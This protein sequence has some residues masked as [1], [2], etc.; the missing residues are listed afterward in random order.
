MVNLNP[1]L[2]MRNVSLV[3]GTSVAA[4]SFLASVTDPENDPITKYA[5]WDGG[6][7]GGR[8][9]LNGVVQPAGKW[10]VVAAAD[11]GS[12]SYVAAAGNG[13]ERIFGTVYD[14]SSWS[15]TVSA[16]AT[17]FVPVNPRPVV[18][19]SDVTVS[20][21]QSIA[22]SAFVQSVTDANAD[23]ITKYSFY[24]SGIGGGRFVLNGVV[25]QAGKWIVVDA[26]DLASLTYV[27]FGV[28]G[29]ERVLVRA[30]DGTSWSIARGAWATTVN[31]A[32]VVTAASVSV[33][34]FAAV[35]AASLISSAVD[36]DGDT[37]KAYR[38]LDAGIGG[39][40]FTLNG[41][42]QAA[43]VWIAIGAD[44]LGALSYVGGKLPGAETIKIRAFDGKVW[45][46]PVSTTVT[47][48]PSTSDPWGMLSDAA[49]KADVVRLLVGN[50]LDY[51]GLLQIMQD[52]AVGGI[53]AAEFTSLKTL[54]GL[55][56]VTGGITV[57]SYLDDIANH[58]INGDPANK[59]WTGGGSTHVALGNLASGTT[60]TQMDRLI[61]KWLLGTD[62]PTAMSGATYKVDNDPLY[63]V[64]G[65]PVYSD[66]NQGS[67]GDCYLLASFAEI[68]LRDPGTLESMFTDNG[69]GTY[70]VRFF[71]DGKARYVTIDSQLPYDPL[72][73]DNGSYLEY[74]NGSVK[75]AAL[76][77]KAYV[78]LNSSVATAGHVAGNAYS[79]IEAGWADPLTDITGKSFASYWTT[80][81][82]AESGWENNKTSI[83]QAI[84]A[85][86]EV[87]VG[88]GSA[89][90]GNL[91]GGHM[92][93]VLG[94]NS[95]NDTF[96]LYNPWGTAYNG[97]VA[98]T[99]EA[100]MADLF[101]NKAT[102]V[103]AQG[104]A[105]A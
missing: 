35:S 30:F 78:Q 5:F 45:S 104:Q 65:A 76:A 66:V 23:P 97:G 84:T 11:L 14:G 7:G 58:L 46:T 40:Y 27:G 96:T 63:G 82:A 37:I 61:G 43:G 91:I 88:S 31:H 22:A 74:A 60:E 42:R 98:I 87:L 103:T 1:T 99:F 73:W 55:F 44:K 95:G 17:S 90:T 25:Q 71:V 51:A 79:L 26:A 38:F 6:V 15:P 9:V 13:A 57:S 72:A 68:A 53:T 50:S 16:M 29:S 54:D 49:I 36:P 47:S 24:D 100:S 18:T 64:S 10:I 94:Y 48:T 20:A 81:Y 77:E 28:G 80:D 83:V 3:A 62:L 59:S 102:V 75:W 21:N 101:A 52:A 4:S 8:L 12:L 67:L 93:A 39:G 92:F 85:G 2:T 56:N 41:V 19:T 105:L 69:N 86:Q 89:D 33:E 32:V 34:A 70:G